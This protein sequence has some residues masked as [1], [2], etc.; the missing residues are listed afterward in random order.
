MNIGLGEDISFSQSIIDKY[1][2]VVHGFDPTP[3]SIKYINGLNQ[4]NFILPAYAE[5]HA[6]EGVDECVAGN[7]TKLAGRH[8]ERSRV[9]FGGFRRSMW[10]CHGC[11]AVGLHPTMKI[12]FLI[13]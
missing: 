7:P 10:R 9:R 4:T 12:M 13:L 3:R 6:S 8:A 2:L 11:K 1:G 5:S